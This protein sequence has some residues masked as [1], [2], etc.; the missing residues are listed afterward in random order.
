MTVKSVAFVC[1][2]RCYNGAMEVFRNVAR[3]LHARGIRTCY[4]YHHERPDEKYP[5]MSMFDRV[6]YV[7][8]MIGTGVSVDR[9]ELGASMAAVAN[10]YD[11]VHHALIPLDWRFC[12]KNM[13]TRP[14][15]ETYHS[16]V[17][18]RDLAWP[19]YQFR[20]QGGVE[21]WPEAMTAVSRGLA[22]RIQK[23]TGRPVSCVCNG[24]PVPKHIDYSKREYVTYAGRISADKG[25]DEWLRIAVRLQESRPDLKFQWVGELSPQYDKFAFACLQAAAPWLEVTGF[26]EDLGPFYDRSA[27][28]M[29]TSP[30]EGL[31]M[32]LIEAMMH[33]VPCVAYDVGDCWETGCGIMRD[34]AMMA[35][36]APTLA[37]AGDKT[38]ERIARE[39]A[40][41]FSDTRMA[42]EYLAIYE[43][44][45]A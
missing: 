14:Q 19:Q 7:P 20:I 42:E 39:T 37:C 1:N 38:R 23:D 15:V 41:K 29:H 31:P 45:L 25:L 32:V 18:W 34:A 11:V 10:G 21:K 40:A 4:V 3:V 2:Y 9:A 36:I 6:A 16:I 13:L 24:V 33:G 44:L 12:F 27:V 17:G 5:D 22:E 35:V 28:L 8:Q 30:A 43:R 26:Q